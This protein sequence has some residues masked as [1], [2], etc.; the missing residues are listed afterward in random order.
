MSPPAAKWRTGRPGS[1]AD[2]LAEMHGTADPW[3]VHPAGMY[4]PVT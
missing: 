2:K 3:V 1:T 4:E